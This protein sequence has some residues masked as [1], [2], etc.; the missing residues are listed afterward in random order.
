[1]DISL[2][3]VMSVTTEQTLSSIQKKSYISIFC[4]FMSFCDYIV[5]FVILEALSNKLIKELVSCTL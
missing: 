1:M 4:D 2:N 3:F 5:M